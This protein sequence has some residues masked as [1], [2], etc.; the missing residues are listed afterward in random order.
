MPRRLAPPISVFA[1][2]LGHFRAIHGYIDP[3]SGYLSCLELEGPVKGRFG[4]PRAPFCKLSFELELGE[5]ISE[6]AYPVDKTKP[7]TFKVCDFPS[8]FCG[9]RQLIYAFV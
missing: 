9:S 3:K 4:S 1:D 7:F 6:V 2:G 5:T 8:D